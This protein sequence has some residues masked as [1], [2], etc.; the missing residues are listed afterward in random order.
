MLRIGVL[1]AAR[2]APPAIIAPA[3]KRDDCEIVAVAARDAERATAFAA[4]HGIA[5]GLAAYEDLISDPGIDLV[6][7]ALPPNRHADLTIAAL[8]AGKHVLCEKPFAMN[9]G[10]ARR[11]VDAAART[12]RYLIEA[13]HYRFHPAFIDVLDKVRTRTI[14]LIKHIDAE[15]SVAIPY[16]PEELRHRPDLGGGAL[17]DLGC[18]PCHWARTLI[19]E[20]PKVVKAEAEEGIGG[21]DVVMMAD[22]VFPDGA[23]ARVRTSMAPGVTRRATLHVT[24]E[25]GDL[26]F[27]NPLAPHLGHEIALH[28]N[29]K[30]HRY[31]VDGL[32]TYD[33]QLAHVIDVLAGRTAPL[34]GSADAVANMT[35]IDAIYDAAGM[36]PRGQAA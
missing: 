28:Q 24:G 17:M 33:H 16:S 7:N 15:F 6:Y 18:Y 29:G 12:G 34:T 8:K 10:E 1:G 5:K 19:G 14:G 26:N 13:F 23:T 2:I 9:A 32:T 36:L 31:S 30:S 22:L 21:I 3:M 4:Q 20:T 11:M 35:L 25:D 27:I